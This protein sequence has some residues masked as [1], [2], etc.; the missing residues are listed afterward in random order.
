MNLPLHLFLYVSILAY[1]HVDL[2]LLTL[3]CLGTVMTA[4]HFLELSTFQYV[5][6]HPGNYLFDKPILLVSALIENVPV[7]F[8]KISWS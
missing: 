2:D 1:L 4:L 3:K 6:L 7:Y 5:C 8:T